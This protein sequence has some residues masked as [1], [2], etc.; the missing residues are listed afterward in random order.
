MRAGLDRNSNILLPLDGL[1]NAFEGRIRVPVFVNHQKHDRTQTFRRGFHRA[2]AVTHRGA[3]PI[4]P[5]LKRRQASKS[6]KGL[7]LSLEQ[8]P[9]SC[10]RA[11]AN[12]A[13]SL[14]RVRC[15]RPSPRGF[16][17]NHHRSLC[18]KS[19]QWCCGSERRVLDFRAN[20]RTSGEAPCGHLGPP[21]RAFAEDASIYR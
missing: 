9:Q 17:N 1:P 6:R 8:R 16:P 4:P 14:W 12:E 3:S 13:R 19:R 21:S 5:R 10:H 7:R 2:H 20:A 11:I 15:L 18:C